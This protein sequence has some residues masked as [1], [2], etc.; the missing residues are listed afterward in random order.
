MSDRGYVEGHFRAAL[1]YESEELGPRDS[2]RVAEYTLRA[3]ASDS[4]NMLRWIES[5]EIAFG[6]DTVSE[7][8]DRLAA[9][10][11]YTGPID[12]DLGK[13][14]IQALRQFRFGGLEPPPG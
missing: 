1:L 9:L 5:R 4:G 2:K 12:G 13:N 11:Y 3:V 7:L 6:K 10:G 8:Q 14:T